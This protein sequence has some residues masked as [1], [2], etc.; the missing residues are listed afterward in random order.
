MNPILTASSTTYVIPCRLLDSGSTDPRKIPALKRSSTRRQQKDR[1]FCASCRH[2]VTDLS[3]EMEIQGK[4]IHFHTNPHGFDFRFACY[5]R[6]PGCRAYGPATAEH[7]WFQGYSWQLA[8]CAACGEHL[9]W[10]YQGEN[11]FFGLILDRLEL[12]LPGH[13]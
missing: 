12:E 6:A 10:R 7:S 5:G 13:S 3:E 2:L 1:V 11:I 4:H 9:G 8:L